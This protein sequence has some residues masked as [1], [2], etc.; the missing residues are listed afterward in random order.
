LYG[1]K[2]ILIGEAQFSNWRGLKLIGQ[3][4]VRRVWALKEEEKKPTLTKTRKLISHVKDYY[5]TPRNHQYNP[6]SS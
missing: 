1:N 4:I 5:K 3:P 6:V 2:Q